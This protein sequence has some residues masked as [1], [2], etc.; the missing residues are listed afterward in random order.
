[1]GKILGFVF[2]FI[3][4]ILTIYALNMTITAPKS[5]VLNLGLLNDQQNY[6][7]IAAA[8][9]ISGVFAIAADEIIEAI[10]PKPKE[11]NVDTE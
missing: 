4:G 7:I 9:F 10:N 5:E 2:C 6:I 11:Q 1:M 8:L 3:S